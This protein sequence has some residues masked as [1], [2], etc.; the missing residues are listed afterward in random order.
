MSD[1]TQNPHTS[2]AGLIVTLVAVGGS[3]IGVLGWH[4]ISNRSGGGLDTSGFD[5]STAPETVRRPAAPPPAPEASAPQAPAAPALG[6]GGLMIKREETLK[7]AGNSPPPAAAPASAAGARPAGDKA[8]TSY[9]DVAMKHEKAVDSY[10]RRMEAK[11]PSIKQYGKDWV[12]HPDLVKLRDDYW[13]DR[14]PVKFAYGV[15]K[16][17]GFADLVKKYAGDPGIRETLIGGIKEA[18]PGLMAAVGGLVKNDGV[19]KQLIHTVAEAAGMPKSLMPMID[20][21]TQKAPDANA[22]LSD[23][24]SSPDLK[25]QMQQQAPPVSLDQNAIDKAKEQAPTNGFTPRRPLGSGTRKEGRP[26]RAGGLFTPGRSVVAGGVEGRRTARRRRRGRRAVVLGRGHA[27]IVLQHGAGA[28]AVGRLRDRAV[29]RRV[30]GRLRA[31]RARGGP[32]H[33]QGQGDGGQS[34]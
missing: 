18:P 28:A 2:R 15:A 33:A 13:K 1:A 19:V 6:A 16:S 11:Y 20:G 17:K 23:I 34:H 5:M 3:A 4:L 10:V 7:V 32:E 22:V 8:P 26:A 27:L 31:A 29:G 12:K 24:M 30:V 9:R 21:D 25:K 14:D